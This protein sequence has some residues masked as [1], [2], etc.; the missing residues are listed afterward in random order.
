VSSVTTYFTGSIRTS[1]TPVSL[2]ESDE[3]VVDGFLKMTETEVEL[4]GR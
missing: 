4:D 3:N 2:R 1:F